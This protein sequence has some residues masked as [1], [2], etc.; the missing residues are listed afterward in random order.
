MEQAEGGWQEKKKE[1]RAPREGK[2]VGGGQDGTQE[3][4]NYIRG[5][6]NKTVKESHECK[7]SLMT[8]DM[9]HS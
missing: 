2:Q 1:T 7:Q 3:R 8:M 6:L 5:F 4:N 9:L